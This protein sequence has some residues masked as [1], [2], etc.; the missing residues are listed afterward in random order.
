MGLAAKPR[1]GSKGRAP[2]GAWGKPP[3]HR[4][5]RNMIDN[6][7]PRYCEL[8][9]LQERNRIRPEGGNFQNS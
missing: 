2:D 3:E 8:A 7:R 5:R 1:V 6:D 4:S 9:F